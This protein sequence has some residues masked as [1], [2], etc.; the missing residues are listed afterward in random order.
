[1]P[2]RCPP[3]SVSVARIAAEYR[4]QFH[5]DVVV[6]LIGFRRHAT[7]KSTIHH[8]QPDSTGSSRTT[9]AVET[10]I[11]QASTK[12]SSKHNS[13]PRGSDFEAAQKRT[14]SNQEEAIAPSLCPAIENFVGAAT[15]LPTK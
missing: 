1:M 12:R 15:K 13:K 4:Y 14:S 11:P 6:D 5:G 8:H 7:A 10:L 9:A 3:L 2:E